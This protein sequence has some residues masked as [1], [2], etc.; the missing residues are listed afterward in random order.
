MITEQIIKQLFK[1]MSKAN[2][3]AA[4]KVD[5][6][7][8][9]SFHTKPGTPELTVTFNTNAVM[10]RSVLFDQIGFMEGYFDGDI[11]ISD[12]HTFIKFGFRM[13]RK[14]SSLPIRNPLSLTAQLWLEWR[15]NNRNRRQAKRNAEHHYGMPAEFFR[16]FLGDT[17]GYTEGYYENG[18]ESLDVAQHKKFEY[19]CQKLMLKP[20]DKLVEVGSGWGYMAV[21]AAQKYGAHVVNYGLVEEQNKVL[22]SWVEKKNLGDKVKVVVKDHRELMNEPEK[23]DKY[24]SI[25]V[26]EHAG[27][28][29]QEDWVK[30][31]A[32]CLKPDGIGVISML[33]HMNRQRTNYIIDKFIFPGGNMPSLADVL[34][35]MEDNGLTVIDMESM[36]PHYLKA[37]QDWY[38]LFVKNWPKIQALN[39]EL[40]NERFY[41]IW[42]VYLLGSIEGFNDKSQRLNIFHIVFVKGR[43][44]DA[45]PQNREFLYAEKMEDNPEI[46]FAE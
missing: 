45:Y 9:S 21:L 42:S 40:F 14:G 11:D 8:G 38:Q 13:G 23:Y 22:E 39:P 46:L 27:L 7:N 5:F 24:V 18:N 19:I 30:S 36:R 12:I 33:T 26:Y 34:K 29:C 41:R 15:T 17:Y 2:G 4:I 20:G 28:N 31:I 44:L 43:K 10:R 16:L 1:Y 25:G 32:A 37:L 6:P 35:Y 3:G